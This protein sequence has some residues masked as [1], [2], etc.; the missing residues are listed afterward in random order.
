MKKSIL[1]ALLGLLCA[2][3]FAHDFSYEEVTGAT[4]FLFTL[5]S[6]T[7]S[8]GKAIEVAYADS[9]SKKWIFSL[10]GDFATKRCEVTEADGSSV[11]YV[12]E[13]DAIA[14]EGSSKGREL[15]ARLPIDAAPW[16]ETM[17]F[18]L[19]RFA[20]S[21]GKKIEFWVVETE[22]M[23]ARLYTSGSTRSESEKSSPLVTRAQ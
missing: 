9:S 22:K 20:L 6:R 16:Y 15:R 12:R 2:S 11:S 19:G 7:D 3:L 23:K 13:K 8:E 4:R 21:G 10:D 5:H 17:E 1:G 18:G 14:I